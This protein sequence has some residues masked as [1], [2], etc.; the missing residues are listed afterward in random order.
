MLYVY[1]E[2]MKMQ[3][4]L[5]KFPRLAENRKKIAEL[6]RIKKYLSTRPE[7]PF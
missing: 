5:D 1:I 6:P 7:T 3:E 4:K 2:N